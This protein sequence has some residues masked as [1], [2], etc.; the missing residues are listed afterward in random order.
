MNDGIF[1]IALEEKTFA[2]FGYRPSDLP[3]F[4]MRKIRFRCAYCLSEYIVCISTVARR[5]WSGCCKFCSGIA[6][7]RSRS[8]ST[9]SERDYFLKASGTRRG[10]PS[11][12]PVASIPDYVDRDRTRTIFGYAPGDL[13]PK[14]GK[15]VCVRCEF[16]ESPHSL[17]R[18]GLLPSFRCRACSGVDLAFR[19]DPG[20]LDK[21]AFFLRLLATI[22]SACDRRR[23]VEEHG[24][25]PGVHFSSAKK[26]SVSC[27]ECGLPGLSPRTDYLLSHGL[28]VS[29][30]G[31]RRRKTVDTLR[32]R[33][34]V[35]NVLDIP[36]VK[37]SYEF[38]LPE[39]IV[40][41]AL[42]DRYGVEYV[43]QFSVDAGSFQYS[44]DFFVPS[45]NLLIECQGDY[46]HD[47]KKNGYSGTPRDRAKAT[48]VERYTPY[49]LVW[50]WEHEV[51][52]GRVVKIL[53]HH[54]HAIL[55]PSVV[56]GNLRDMEVRKISL[57]EAHSFL[58][59]YHYLGG[60][61]SHSRC[62]GAFYGGL[63]LSVA[64][65]GGPT[66]SESGRKLAASTGLPVCPGSIRELRRFC[67]RP[68]VVCEN[69]GSFLLS[70]FMRLLKNDDATASVVVAFSDSTVADTGGLYAAS[71]FSRS[72]ETGPSYHY[73]DV[74][75][76]RVMHKKTVWNMASRARMAEKDFASTL[77]LERVPESSKSLWFASI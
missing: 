42:R 60:V 77:G 69:L 41:S 12:S 15:R 71:N 9:V 13:R 48:Y 2:E 75:T 18:S 59:L 4:S 51:H 5:G 33:Y 30:P 55:E 63:L 11:S 56:V 19:A 47:F 45:C 37:A 14:S 21:R 46:F 36:S 24:H 54:I 62:Y 44:F 49:K 8:G 23:T 52:V 65:F 66:R 34:G 58:S 61:G 28:R 7:A 53:D 72:H 39:R 20:G 3:P 16:C 29:C 67:I 35:S 57:P 73:L 38:S 70:K 50:I 17:R 1:E 40:A 64:T 32:D 27:C 10:L 76:S 68:N 31:C 22:C 43:S 26:L 25:D 6:S 74:C